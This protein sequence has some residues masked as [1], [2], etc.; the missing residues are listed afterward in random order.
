MLISCGSE[1]S[2]NIHW[3]L[4]G[5]LFT[6]FSSGSWAT[7]TSGIVPVG[8]SS[9]VGNGNIK[10]PVETAV[11]PGGLLLGTVLCSAITCGH[12]KTTQNSNTQSD[13]S[14]TAPGRQ[15]GDKTRATLQLCWRHPRLLLSL[16]SKSLSPEQPCCPPPPPLGSSVTTPLLYWNLYSQSKVI[17]LCSCRI[18]EM[19]RDWKALGDY[20]GLWSGNKENSC[21]AHN[22]TSLSFSFPFFLFPLSPHRAPLIT[23]SFLTHRHVKKVLT[24]IHSELKGLKKK[25]KKNS[26]TIILFCPFLSDCV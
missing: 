10:T 2:T 5:S 17:L 26:T 19:R 22:D 21:S 11:L 3:V 15:I 12:V 8:S 13:I 20:S 25:E 4:S 9:C 6:I 1:F 14:F 16:C 24:M 7:W 18:S 23:H